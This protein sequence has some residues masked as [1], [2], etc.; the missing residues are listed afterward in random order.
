ME[1]FWP[2][3]TIFIRL[4]CSTNFDII[5]SVFFTFSYKCVS[6]CVACVW[7]HPAHEEGQ[8]YW[9]FHGE[10]ISLS[11]LSVGPTNWEPD[12]IVKQH[13]LIWNIWGVRV[14]PL[15]YNQPND[16]LYRDLQV[17]ID[18]R[19]LLEKARLLRIRSFQSWWEVQNRIEAFYLPEPLTNLF[20]F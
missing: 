20:Y 1:L 4:W 15:S 18:P 8:H 2:K 11:N 13:S 17:L 10:Q 12:H 6:V 7:C 9:R 16:F 5:K 14:K 3:F 19:Y